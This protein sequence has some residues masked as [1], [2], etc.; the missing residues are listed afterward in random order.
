MSASALRPHDIKYL[1]SSRMNYLFTQNPVVRLS[2]P[3]LGF[4]LYPRSRR[5]ES[6]TCVRL[7][8][9][10]H[11]NS[12][13]SAPDGHKR[14]S[15]CHGFLEPTLSSSDIPWADWIDHSGSTITSS[16]LE[17]SHWAG[18]YRYG[19]SMNYC[20]EKV[21]YQL[22][23]HSCVRAGSPHLFRDRIHRWRSGYFSSRDPIF[24]YIW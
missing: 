4:E 1:K 15:D 14:S 12:K 3:P 8:I 22:L 16:R 20:Q 23:G 17:W 18:E 10:D 5:D 2:E 11:S 9:P 6:I 21:C 7:Q 13:R 19:N 24:R